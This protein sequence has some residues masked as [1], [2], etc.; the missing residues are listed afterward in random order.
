MPFFFGGFGGYPPPPLCGQY[1]GEKLLAELGGGTGPP[2]P[3]FPLSTSKALVKAAFEVVA[4][5]RTV[6]T[7]SARHW[8]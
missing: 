3:P 5:L 4:P 2:H 8:W 1:F 6:L 7:G